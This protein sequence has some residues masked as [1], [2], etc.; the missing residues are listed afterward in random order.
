[1][2]TLED[3]QYIKLSHLWKRNLVDEQKIRLQKL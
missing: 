2:N 1:M 3:E